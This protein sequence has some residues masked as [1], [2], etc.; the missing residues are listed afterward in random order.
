MLQS[1]LDKITM[2][3]IEAELIIKKANEQAKEI[4]LN[5][6]SAVEKRR[7]SFSLEQKTISDKV[8]AVAQKDSD[9]VYN[10]AIK[11]AEKKAQELTATAKK[12]E[13]QAVDLILKNLI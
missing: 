12:N 6:E 10:A 8:F 13:K 9:I 1:Q 11:D 7:E 3:E 2:A 4:R 5:V